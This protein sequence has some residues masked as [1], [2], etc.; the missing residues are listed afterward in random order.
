MTSALRKAISTFTSRGTFHDEEKLQAV[1]KAAKDEERLSI[2]ATM[3]HCPSCNGESVE[4]QIV[5]GH[6]VCTNYEWHNLRGAIN[7][8]IEQGPQK[9]IQQK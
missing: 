7:A 6:Y 3:T 1:I 5:A 4:P 9:G 2:Y 8:I